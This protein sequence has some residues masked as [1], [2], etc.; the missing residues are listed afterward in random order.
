M[1]E[2]MKIK[3]SGKE[4]KR[5]FMIRGMLFTEKGSGT[6]FFNCVSNFKTTRVKEFRTLKTDRELSYISPAL[7][8]IKKLRTS[9]AIRMHL[10]CH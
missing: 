2:K 9:G 4:K 1:R 3:S 8:Q 6:C 5:I 10:A 7:W